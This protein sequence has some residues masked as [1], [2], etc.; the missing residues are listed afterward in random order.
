MVEVVPARPEDL[1]DIIAWLCS[2]AI[3]LD[4]FWLAARP[5]PAWVRRS[6]LVVENN[7]GVELQRVRIWSVLRDRE[8]LG[9][10]IDFGWDSPED[11]ER[12]V[13]FALPRSSRRQPRLPVATLAA[14]VHALFER[15]ATAVWGRVRVAGGEGFPRLFELI[16]G[17]PQ[18]V[19]FD[20]MPTTGERRARAY[21]KTTPET[22][23]SSRFGRRVPSPG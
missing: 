11:T 18:G 20:E 14:V 12:E 9:F 5:E 7:L 15:G 6:M 17:R 13:D 4:A 19:R 10:A 1:D 8:L 23:Y 21:F 16:G 3:Y 2:P 22:F